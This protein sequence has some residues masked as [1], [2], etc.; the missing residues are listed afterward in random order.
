M[1]GHTR[2]LTKVRY[3]R[4]GDLIFATA[5]DHHPTVWYSANGE[6]LGS[7]IGHSGAV[8]DC[9]VNY[10]TTRLL[11]A[12]SDT[13][14]K[15]WDVETGKVLCTFQHKCPVRSVAFAHGGTMILTVQDKAMQQTPAIFIF[16]L[17][18]EG[19]DAVDSS[20]S[21]RR[22]EPELDKDVKINCALWGAL[23]QTIICCCDDGTLRL[24]DVAD[25]KE[26]NVVVAHKSPI[27][28][29]TFSKDQTMF[30]SASSDQTAK[31]W[32]VKDNTLQ[33]M[34]EYKCDRPLNAAAISPVMNHVIMGGGQEAM[35]VTTTAAKQGRFEVEFFHTFYKEQL[36]NVKGHFGPVN[37][38]AFSPDGTSFVSGGE[39]GYI[40][41]H[42][43]D[44]KYFELNREKDE[45]KM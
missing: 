12:S 25:G 4:D 36:G 27:K 40:R 43:F 42:H 5:K 2:P 23:N 1:K 21:V 41:L 31:L 33:C 35:N 3:N 18:E 30:I 34:K 19:V 20:D 8:N 24:W 16:N 26:L 15:L 7:Y 10:E 44:A 32:S 6:R 28:N 9:D 17:P 29:I 22:F 38:L 45:K 39:D 37:S 11:T 13:T 14:A